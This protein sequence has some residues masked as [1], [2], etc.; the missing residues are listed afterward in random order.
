[1]IGLNHHQTRGETPLNRPFSNTVEVKKFLL[2]YIAADKK[3]GPYSFSSTIPKLI[4]ALL[5][6]PPP[7]SA[8]THSHYANLLVKMSVRSRTRLAGPTSQFLNGTHEFMRLV[9]AR[10]ALF[11]DES[12]SALPLQSAKAHLQRKN[13]IQKT[14][15]FLTTLLGKKIQSE[16]TKNTKIPKRER[17]RTGYGIP[18]EVQ[19]NIKSKL[20]K[21]MK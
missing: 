20:D 8:N 3:K 13:H 5:L 10:M 2:Q 18:C 7:T 1:M 12:R 17:A 15:Y 19:P 9:Q 11:M 4:V 6:P 16:L 21:T 14:R